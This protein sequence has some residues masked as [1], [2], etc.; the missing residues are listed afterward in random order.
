MGERLS[1][2]GVPGRRRVHP[3]DAASGPWEPRDGSALETV[4]AAVLR[5]GDRTAEA[6]QRAVSAFRAARSAGAPRARTRRRDDWR[7]PAG[8]R[9][10]RPV[11]ATFAAVFA[12]L[13]LGGVAVAA[14]GSAKLVH[15][16][17]RYRPE[18]RA[19]VGLRPDPAGR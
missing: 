6:E 11:K 4:L 12:S 3:D 8:R 10:G 16:R 14:I 15:G 5:E 1:G 9:T 13:T 2:D 19:P 7:L 18:A 17:R